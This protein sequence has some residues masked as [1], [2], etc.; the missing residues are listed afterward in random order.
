M[1]G[2][3]NRRAEMRGAAPA[4]KP[5]RRAK[6]AQ[7]EALPC[8]AFCVLHAY[9]PLQSTTW[10]AIISSVMFILQLERRIFLDEM[11][12]V[13]PIYSGKEVF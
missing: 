1:P 6:P 12:K 2:I 7:R 9:F 3:E 8:G 5:P 4:A 13:T 10:H 11:R